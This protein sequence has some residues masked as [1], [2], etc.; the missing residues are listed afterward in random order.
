MLQKG[1]ENLYGIT[2]HGGNAAGREGRIH[3]V[4][5]RDLVAMLQVISQ[6]GLMRAA[7]GLPSH[8]PPVVSNRED[9]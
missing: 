1:V 8:L 4:P 3:K 6:D 9:M 5:K 2:I 7:E